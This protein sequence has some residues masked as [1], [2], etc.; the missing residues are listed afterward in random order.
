MAKSRS[1]DDIVA[2]AE[3]LLRVW[4]DNDKLSLGDVTREGFQAMLATFKTTRSHT[5]D[6][7]TQLTAS[8][9]DTNSQAS[10]IQDLVVRGR[11]G[12]R[13]QFGADSTQYEQLG[14]TRA[15]ERKPR[16]KKSS[17]KS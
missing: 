3:R 1:F 2:D 6:L 11:S 4:N 9:N 10:A 7:R 14:G 13:A 16:A 5:E 12:A 17:P 8:V 15:S